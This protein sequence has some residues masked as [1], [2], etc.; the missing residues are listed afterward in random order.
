V[1]LSLTFSLQCLG[2]FSSVSSLSRRLGLWGSLFLKGPHHA[3]VQTELEGRC[4]ERGAPSPVIAPW[5][6]SAQA[7]TSC[8]GVWEVELCFPGF[9]ELFINTAGLL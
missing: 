9:H 3:A 5:A 8:M 2:V 4:S 1:A 7:G 6:D